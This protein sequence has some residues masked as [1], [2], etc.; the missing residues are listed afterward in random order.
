MNRTSGEKA[1]RP[2]GGYIQGGFLLK[3]RGFEYDAKYGVPGRPSTAKAIELVVRFNYTDMNDDR[4][5]IYGGE[6]KDLSLGVNFY[7]NQYIGVKV[8]GSY[9]WVGPHCNAFYQKTFSWLRLVFNIF[10]D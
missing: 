10:S 5:E 6:E 3:G 8:N 2:H 1:Y 9:V 4:A 7:L